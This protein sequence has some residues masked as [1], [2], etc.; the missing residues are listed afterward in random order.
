MAGDECTVDGWPRAYGAEVDRVPVELDE[1]MA[2]ACLWDPA[3]QS[4]VYFLI[5][6]GRVDYVGQSLNVLGRIAE[7]QRR[8][9]RFTHVS[10]VLAPPDELLRIE[11]LY[12]R[13]FRPPWN[14]YEPS[15]RAAYGEVPIEALRAA[16]EGI[17]RARR[18]EEPG[19]VAPAG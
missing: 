4:G 7:H 13:A 12:I 5:N 11:K 16:V 18:R 9:R 3:V 8:G 1:V 17:G 6:D 15:D 14:R 2:A 10:I 19:Q